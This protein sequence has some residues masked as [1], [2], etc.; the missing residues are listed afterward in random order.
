MNPSDYF[1]ALVLDSL[2]TKKVKLKYGDIIS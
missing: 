1:S 2:G